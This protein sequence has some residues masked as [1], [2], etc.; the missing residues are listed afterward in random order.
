[1]QDLYRG[2]AAQPGRVKGAFILARPV[3]GSSRRRGLMTFDL[4][5][6]GGSL[7]SYQS[8]QQQQYKGHGHRAISVQNTLSLTS[9]MN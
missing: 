9:Y 8:I 5:S 4:I 3:L 6:E 7:Q 2:K 1:V